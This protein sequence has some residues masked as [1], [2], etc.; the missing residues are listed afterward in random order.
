VIQVQ[1]QICAHSRTSA[2]KVFDSYPFAN[3]GSRR[4]DPSLASCGCPLTR[5]GARPRAPCRWGKRLDVEWS[6]VLS[7]LGFRE[8]RIARTR[9]FPGVVWLP[10]DP[11]GRAS[12]RAVQV[13]QAVR[14]RMVLGFEHAG[15]PRTA[16]RE[17][18]I[19]HRRSISIGGP[20]KIVQCSGKWP[21]L[22]FFYEAM[23]DRIL[24]NVRPLRV[25]AITRS[26]LCVPKIDLPSERR[27]RL[28]P[29]N[30]GQPFP[31]THPCSQRRMHYFGRSTE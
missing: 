28:S 4:R 29:S 22:R 19:P 6:S 16:D 12:S 13:G 24:V 17:D 23:P 20:N 11:G 1:R 10:P 25:V 2:V 3:N 30:R 31:V 26:K 21:I 15:L 8:R 14:R 27:I 7:T 9:S 18:A 5:E